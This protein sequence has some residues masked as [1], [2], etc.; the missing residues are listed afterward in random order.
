MTAVLRT[1]IAV[2]M[3]LAV[4]VVVRPDVARS[5]PV[6]VAVLLLSMVALAGMRYVARGGAR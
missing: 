2:A 5:G 3:V 1:A 4:T 6:V